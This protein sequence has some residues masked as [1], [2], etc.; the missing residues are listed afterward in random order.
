MSRHSFCF[1]LWLVW[2]TFPGSVYLSAQT[3]SASTVSDL[4]DVNFSR[5]TALLHGPWLFFPGRLL[6]PLEISDDRQ[7]QMVRVPHAWRIQEQL[8]SCGTYQVRVRLPENHHQLLLYFPLVSSAS[9]IWIDTI[10]VAE[11]GRIGCS[12]EYHKGQQGYSLIHLPEAKREITITVQVSNFS[13]FYGGLISTPEIGL[14]HSIASRLHFKRSWSNLFCGSLFAIAVIHVLLYSLFRK[15]R[16]YLYLALICLSVVIRSFVLNRGSLFLPELLPFIDMEYFKR[17]EFAVV[18]LMLGLFPLYIASVFNWKCSVWIIRICLGVSA[19]LTAIACFG[20]I[21]LY[22]SLLDVAHVMFVAEFVFA[23]YMLWKNRSDPEYRILLAGIIASFPPIA[24]E[25]AVNSGLLV[26]PF[27]S[28]HLVELGLLIFFLFHTFLLAK[29]NALTFYKVE[30]LNQ[31][32][33]SEVATRT[34]E[35]L[36]S[37][38]VKNSLLSV[39]SHD[40]KSPLHAI[41][42][43]LH[44]YNRR[45]ITEEEL[46]PLM[47]QLEKNTM[48]TLH[49]VDNILSWA[50]SQTEGIKISRQKVNLK[51]L[52]DEHISIFS[53]HALLK[54]IMLVNLVHQDVAVQADPDVIRLTLRNLISNA[55]KFTPR[56]GL[57]KI[58]ARR[59]ANVVALHVTDSGVGMDA[60]TVRN[61]FRPQNNMKFGTDNEKG[62]GIGLSLCKYFLDE[63]G[64]KVEVTSTP[65]LGTTVMV[66]L[67]DCIESAVQ[68][69]ELEPCVADREA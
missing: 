17:L 53:Q 9:R 41:A 10:A 46:N 26:L 67:D 37:S 32:L 36:K 6:T 66:C 44:L 60:S 43:I 8:F 3:L 39:I 55:L 16:A 19:L 2:A 68:Q 13:Y 56:N 59:T 47:S 48:N 15:E 21:S 65:G 25:I 29:R 28:G 27:P 54:S 38:Q 64:A 40:L 12:K 18:Y 69:E 61:L 52:V 11:K 4:H 42:S 5:E 1:V 20:P 45:Q 63:M 58:S 35:L 50:K 7:G 57:I 23:G 31:N 14:S 34:A 22:G 49:L 51:N 62:Y 30:A 33:E 24:L